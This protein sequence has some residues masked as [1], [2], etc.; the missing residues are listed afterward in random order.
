MNHQ[1]NILDLLSTQDWIIF[2]FILLVTWVAAWWGM[3]SKKKSA[4][5]MVELLVMG[6]RLT[7]PFFI[8]TL[9]STWYGGIFGVTQIAFEKGIYNFITQ[10]VFWYAAY[11]IF[12]CFLVDKL[13]PYQALGLPNLVCKMAGP[14]SGKL[15][16]IFNFFY[17]LPVAYVVSMGLFLQTLF[18][19]SLLLSMS[20]GMI[21]VLLYSMRGGMAA[22]V[23]SDMVQFF[24]MCTAVFCVLCFSVYSFGWDY[25]SANLP[26]SHFTLT[27]DEHWS[28]LLIWGF[29]A[30]SSL[31]DPNFYQR[32]FAAKNTH[33]AKKGILI[34]TAIW[35]FFDIC[36][37]TGAMYAR[38]YLPQADS[39]KAYLIY[40][41][42]I[43]PEGLRGFFLAGILATI[44]STIDSCLFL[45]GTTLTYDLL[46]QKF[47]HKKIL[48]FSS[49]IL[50]A[51]PLCI[52]GTFIR[53]K[54][55]E[56]LENSGKLFRR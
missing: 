49:M 31:V 44:L 52:A 34:S 32:C 36:T 16:A 53:R 9:V 25:L 43:L 20:T 10:G 42:T 22:I 17:I 26:S 40:G 2:F 28:E 46:P 33:V 38:A 5:S 51:T 55:H 8:G 27:S 21:V 41:L 11:L 14:K 47:H 24:V 54:Y 30:L 4:S 19:G 56:Y 45:A 37:T 18:E 48:Y 50:V 39:G 23:W 1:L 13:A 15:A 3:R 7:L 6:R 12:A 35:V 29:I